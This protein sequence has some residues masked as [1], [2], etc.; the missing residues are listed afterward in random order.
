MGLVGLLVAGPAAAAD[1]AERTTL[2]QLTTLMVEAEKQFGEMNSVAFDSLMEMQLAPTL[3]CLG[4]PLTPTLAR[5]YH[6]L[7]AYHNLDQ[8][9]KDTVEALA[10]ARRLTGDNPSPATT[11]PEGHP[12]RQHY[13]TSSPEARTRR[14]SRP[15]T[16]ALGFDGLITRERPIDRSTIQQVLGEDGAV[17]DTAYLFSRNV[18]ARYDGIR[19]SDLVGADGSSARTFDLNVPL[20]ATTG[21]LAVASGVLYGVAAAS[22]AS[23]K[24][25]SETYTLDELESLRSR[26]NNTGTAAG[27][28]A[29]GA[30]VGLTAFVV[31]GA[32]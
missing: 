21:A 16:G 18:P 28:L 15:K 22:E 2:T 17:L 32:F 6:W 20:L 1:C 9:E 26:T 14:L 27:A 5:R 19:R 4:E 12:I 24:D 25:T 7:V 3:K 10:A 29:I 13:E 31:V 8:Q 23:F 30:G 11:Y